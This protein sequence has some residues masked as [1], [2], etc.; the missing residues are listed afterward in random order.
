MRLRGVGGELD[1]R[2]FEFALDRLSRITGVE[3]TCF[4]GI[5]RSVI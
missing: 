4:A 3:I 1:M 5:R 2:D